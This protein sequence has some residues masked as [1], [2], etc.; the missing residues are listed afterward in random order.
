MW[1][2]TKRIGLPHESNFD[3]QIKVS[4]E[5]DRTKGESR[6]TAHQGSNKNLISSMSFVNSTDTSLPSSNKAPVGLNELDRKAQENTSSE[7][8]VNNVN[9][10]KLIDCNNIILIE[11]D[12]AFNVDFD[13]CIVLEQNPNV[14]IE[15]CN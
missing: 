4:T 13:K 10:S 15:V 12:V 8:C 11:D 1:V 6:P 3:E 5:N 7:H 2:E 9:F 14:I